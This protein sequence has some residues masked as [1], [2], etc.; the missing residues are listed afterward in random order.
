MKFRQF[1]LFWKLTLPVIV[2]TLLW[3]AII[4]I[5][6]SGMKA[7]RAQTHTLYTN[8]VHYVLQLQ[9]LWRKFSHLNHLLLTHVSSADGKQVRSLSEQIYEQVKSVEADFEQVVKLAQ[10]AHEHTAAKLAE[11]HKA[12]RQYVAISTDVIALSEDFEKSAAFEELQELTSD[13]Q[14]PINNTISNIIT[15]EL[16]FMQENHVQTQALWQKNI[17][18]LIVFGGASF[19]LS[20]A[21][22]YWIIYGITQRMS[23]VVICAD[24][25]RKG[26]L[27]ARVNADGYDDE[28]SRLGYGLA[29]MA[30]EVE[31]S[32]FLL[33]E[34]EAQVRMLL[35]ST[36]EAIYGI[37]LDGQC[38]FSNKACLQ[39]LGYE[40]ASELLGKN[41]HDLI[42]HSHEDGRP[43]PI[44]E[45]QIHKSIRTGHGAHSDEEVLWR[46]D[47]SH[48]KAEY[49]SHPIKQDGE[50]L[51]AVISFL[52]ITERKRTE[53][54]L[55]RNHYLL[56]EAQEIGHVGSWEW[57]IKKNT[58]I[59]ADETYRIFGFVPQEFIPTYDFFLY[60]IHP[61][62]REFVLQSVQ[63][64]L[65]SDIPY[66]INHRIVSEGGSE[67]IVNEKGRVNRDEAGTPISL[68]GTIQDITEI[69]KIENDLLTYQEQLED[70]VSERTAELLAAK[71]EADEA[72]Q[73][74]SL[75][76]SSMSHELRTP[77]NSI[78][79]FSELLFTDSNNPVT[80]EQKGQLKKIL[81]S[82]KHLLSLIDD[83]LN[84]SKI[85]SG[86]VEISLEPIDA[87]LAL[88]DTLELVQEIANAQ[89]VKIV[90]EE[91]DEHI[92][93]QVDNTR[94][95]QVLM[96][97]LSNAIKYNRPE[98][99][100][101]I[102]CKKIEGQ[103]RIV[104][105]DTGIGIPKEK[106]KLLFEPF[107]RLGAE[108]SS[109]EGTGIGLTITKRLVEMMNGHIGYE[110]EVGKGSEFWV[111]FPIVESQGEEYSSFPK[112]KKPEHLLPERDYTI[113][114]VEDNK[115]NR[116]LLLAILARTP[117]L[118]LLMAENGEEGIDMAVQYQPDIILMDIGLPDMDGFTVFR[119]LTQHDETV[120]IPVVALSGNAMPMDIEKALRAGFVDY[121]TKPIHI[122]KLYEVIGEVSKN[123]P[124]RM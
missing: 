26:D 38:T 54:A 36:A 19:I 66:D 67:R 69:K 92:F 102:S 75:F 14:Q 11:S 63:D 85:E 6:A 62:D 110:S 27:S 33:Q 105:S 15:L 96:N 44:E 117:H 81:K 119:K 7:S 104:V 121:I 74:K 12:Y 56:N 71:E 20:L 80:I 9:T 103:L 21:F 57:D 18:T 10:A 89:N 37:N 76:L 35:D 2:V 30:K 59:W 47:G 115:N 43:Y 42:H 39:M 82:G 28:I 113:L 8:N 61:E 122:A 79:G 3:G 4:L 93:I 112:A 78:L 51:G 116:D 123:I 58:I 22:L 107:S 98:G 29:V 65:E 24:A 46:R 41:I 90:S 97:L 77:L 108:T 55:L 88:L 32:T 53:E 118:K 13:F 109:I 101:A 17:V 5:T 91:L 100:V 95:R 25:L 99:T 50:T 1:S 31:Q 48:F 111:E 45:C 87:Y 34:S 60:K 94:F 64:T 120:N 23:L 16:E 83:V 40:S 73:A 86:A 124:I 72:N 52:D 114:Y 49:R 68:V 84:L 106:A 70:L